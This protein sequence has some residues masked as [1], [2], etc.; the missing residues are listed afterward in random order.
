MKKKIGCSSKVPF[1]AYKITD[2]DIEI[3]VVRQSS[4]STGSWQAVGRKAI[5]VEPMRL[6]TFSVLIHSFLIQI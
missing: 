3:E 6:K 1:S 2:E 4:G 5:S